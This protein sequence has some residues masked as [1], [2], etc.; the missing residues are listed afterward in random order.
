MLVRCLRAQGQLTAGLA[1]R[2]LVSGNR[3]L[4]EATLAELSGVARQRVA[5]HVANWR[6]GGFSALYARAGLPP[7][8]AP[9]FRAALAAQEECGFVDKPGDSARLSRLMIERVLTACER[10]GGESLAPVMSLLRRFE[11]EA[12]REE[13]RELSETV[14]RETAAAAPPRPKRPPPVIAQLRSRILSQA[15]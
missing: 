12:A 5:G 9:A 14:A 15:A 13:A 11:A 7:A 10:D 6:G 2:A 1:L 4:F 8:L 3:R